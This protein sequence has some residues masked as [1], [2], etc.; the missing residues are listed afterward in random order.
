MIHLNARTPHWSLVIDMGCCYI[1]LMPQSNIFSSS[2]NCR[3]KLKTTS[4][5]WSL[6]DILVMTSEPE[7]VKSSIL[8]KLLINLGR[9]T[10]THTLLFQVI[11]AIFI[12]YFSFLHLKDK[13]SVHCYQPPWFWKLYSFWYINWLSW[14]ME[15]KILFIEVLLRCASQLQSTSQAFLTLHSIAVKQINSGCPVLR[16]EKEEQQ[17]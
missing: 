17:K 16:A 4:R 9:W 14:K 11:F 13:H 8:R 5:Y 3:R 12:S 1:L 15:Q 2:L 6:A 7:I 10:L